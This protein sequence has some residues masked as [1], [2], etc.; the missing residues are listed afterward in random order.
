VAG[1]SYGCGKHRRYEVK[2]AALITPEGEALWTS[3]G[4]PGVTHDLTVARTHG[5]CGALAAAGILTLGDKGYQ[6][7]DQPIHSP[8]KGK[9]LP[10]SYADANKALNRLRAPGECAFAQLK[11]WK[12]LYRYRGCPTRVGDIV[13][14]VLLL[15]KHR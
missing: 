11:T 3:P 10:A 6:G 15:N 12:I 14:A 4:L 2:I 1:R 7:A 5:I 13:T 9:T 8:Y